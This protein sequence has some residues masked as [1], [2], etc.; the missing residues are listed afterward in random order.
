MPYTKAPQTKDEMLDRID[1]LEQ[2]VAE[3]KGEIAE[4]K[5]TREAMEQL[6][7]ASQDIVFADLKEASPFAK[8]VSP[9]GT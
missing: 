3:L 7:Q 5:D 1:E 8:G 4:A 9:I 6:L 2:E